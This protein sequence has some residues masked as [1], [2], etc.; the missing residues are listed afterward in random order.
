MI[1]RRLAGAMVFSILAAL[2]SAEAAPP[3]SN[4]SS[5][6]HIGDKTVSRVTG[7]GG[8]FL[9]AKDPA[10]LRAWYKVHLG[11]DVQAWGGYGVSLVRWF[12]SP[13]FGDHGLVRRRR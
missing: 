6:T 13:H 5:D 1:Y 3:T 10:A 4:N 11:I 2:A 7:I 8:I 12:R 9:K